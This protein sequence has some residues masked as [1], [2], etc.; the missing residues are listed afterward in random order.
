MKPRVKYG[1]VFQKKEGTVACII[2][3]FIAAMALTDRPIGLSAGYTLR[4]I[5]KA[6]I[7]AKDA[8][9][10]EMDDVIAHCELRRAKGVK[11]STVD[12]DISCLTVAMK[13]AGAAWKDCKGI[14]DK[15][16]D[17]V[18]PFLVHHR[19]IAKSEPRDAIPTGEQILMLCEHFD[20]PNPWNRKR[21]PM[22]IITLWQY[23]S[24]RRIGESCK[25]LWEDWSREDQ[26]ILVRKM[27]DPRRRN[28]AKVVGLPPEAQALLVALWDIRD[29][30][31]PRIHPYRAESCIAAYVAAKKATGISGVRLHDS[32]RAGCTRLVAR[33][34]SSAEAI[35]FSGHET[36][37]VFER[38][39][40][41]M[42]AAKVVRDGPIKLRGDKSMWAN[43][44]A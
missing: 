23:Y 16:I 25:L 6:P 44:A 1:D 18:K 2:E 20:R 39:Y 17:E 41:R 10:L 21:I 3:R 30:D 31:E 33:G 15:A 4:N 8:K 26:T 34:Y 28:K 24:L 38:T 22:A 40:L 27:K 32:R 7:G 13:Y 29:P 36:P 37:T 42:D 12:K 14:S 11:P 43:Q 5:A 19:L 9:A 35:T